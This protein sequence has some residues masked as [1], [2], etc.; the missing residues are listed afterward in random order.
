MK[1]IS[2]H[3][4][5]KKSDLERLHF[6]KYN[7]RNYPCIFVHYSSNEDTVDLLFLEWC[8]L[9]SKGVGNQ[10][11]SV[12]IRTN[13]IEITVND[14]TITQD[15]KINLN[16]CVWILFRNGK[17]IVGYKDKIKE[18]NKITEISLPIEWTDPN[19]HPYLTEIISCP[20]H[21]LPSGRGMI[22]DLEFSHSFVSETDLR[23][24]GPIPE[25]KGWI[26]ILVMMVLVILFTL[27]ISR[28]C[29]K[30]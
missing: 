4:L 26:I 29:N 25:S 8:L 13:S 30:P 17:M 6:S 11:I 12:L 10:F 23:E 22:E 24:K 15:A 1:F 28:R 20:N 3:N 18:L 5:S 16:G 21:G 27:I 14:D 9:S 2:K 7:F 19:K